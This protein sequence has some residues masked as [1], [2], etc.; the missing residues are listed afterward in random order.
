MSKRKI[1]LF[2]ILTCIFIFFVGI[3]KVYEISYS[4]F[5]DNMCGNKIIRTEFSP[6][7]KNKIV[8]FL[9]DCG[10]TTDFSTQVSILKVDK[11]LENE[12]GNIFSAD[13]ERGKAKTDENNIV[14]IKSKWI[15]NNKVIITYDKNVRIFKSEN[16]LDEIVIEYMK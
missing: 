5:A 7:K 12:S 16:S 13:S 9:R 11:K 14:A 2:I 10:A 3:Y 15:N 6:D 4:S 1:I 8:I